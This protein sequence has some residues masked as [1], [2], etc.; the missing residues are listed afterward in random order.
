[1]PNYNEIKTR[2]IIRNDTSDNWE[3]STIVLQKGEPAIEIDTVNKTG[4]LKIGDGTSTFSQLPFSTL[5]PDE[6]DTKIANAS[7]GSGGNLT[8]ETL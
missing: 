6:I 8:W 5:T 2:I 1:M 7:S 3:G 4:K